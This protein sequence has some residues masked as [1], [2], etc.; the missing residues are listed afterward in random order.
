MDHSKTDKLKLKTFC[1]KEYC[2][3]DQDIHFIG[4]RNTG[5]SLIYNILEMHGYNEITPG[6]Y[7]KVKKCTFDCN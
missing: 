5:A 3:N 7:K 2:K 1:I 6:H 4:K